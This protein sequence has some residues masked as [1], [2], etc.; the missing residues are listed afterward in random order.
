M[1]LLILDHLHVYF[2]VCVCVCE[3]KSDREK[4]VGAQYIVGAMFP[5]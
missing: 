2:N 1:I 4:E 3:R 5:Q